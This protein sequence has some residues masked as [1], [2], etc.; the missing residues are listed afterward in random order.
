MLEYVYS[1]PSGM[2]FAGSH[3]QAC[4]S[5]YKPFTRKLRFLCCLTT[6]GSGALKVTLES[7]PTAIAVIPQVSAQE[8]SPSVQPNVPDPGQASHAYC[9]FLHHHK[10]LLIPSKPFLVSIKVQRP[11]CFAQW[12]LAQLCGAGTAGRTRQS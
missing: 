5:Y 10:S 9:D 3:S 1:H 12:G 2:S 11:P 8:A 7:S 4:L 6:L